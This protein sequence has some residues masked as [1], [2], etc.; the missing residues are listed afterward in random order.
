M[1]KLRNKVNGVVVDVPDDRAA[2]MRKL[3]YVSVKAPTGKKTEADP[4]DTEN[5]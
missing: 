1:A 2:A 3:G 5:D 4:V